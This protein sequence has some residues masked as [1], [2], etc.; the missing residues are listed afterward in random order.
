MLN[1]HLTELIKRSI[2]G[3]ILVISVGGAYLHS[4]ALFVV[5]LTALMHITLITE[6][7][8]LVDLNKPSR[9]LFSIF[10][11]IV[12]FISLIVLTLRY[13]DADFYLPLLPFILAWSADTGGYVVGKLIGY[14]KMC[15]GISPGKSWE[16]FAGSVVA[17]LCACYYFL[18]KIK[19]LTASS[20]A[21][22]LYATIFF[23]VTM[24]TI[25]FLGGFFLSLLKRKEG[26]KDA[27]SLLPGHGG[28]L[29]RFDGVLFVGIAILVMTHWYNF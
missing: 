17:V 20:I 26:L 8:K 7:P 21:T 13:R 9:L 12:P 1:P 22:N 23:A 4:T 29:D 15:P 3:I 27:G 24:T 10:Y 11:P 14:H 28:I 6:W 19:L 5:A 18:P 25:A 2:T 16:G